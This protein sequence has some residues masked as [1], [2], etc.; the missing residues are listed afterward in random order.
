[1]Q[2]NFSRSVC[3]MILFI[4]KDDLSHLP[5]IVNI[6]TFAFKDATHQTM[7]IVILHLY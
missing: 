5:A 6:P 1:M 2:R 4:A 3:N 7:E